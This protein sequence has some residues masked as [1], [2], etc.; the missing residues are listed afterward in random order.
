M[1]VSELADKIEDYFMIAIYDFC[2]ILL[3]NFDSNLLK[4]SST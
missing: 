4:F 3:T 1:I 2:F